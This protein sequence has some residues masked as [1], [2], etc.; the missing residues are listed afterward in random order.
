MATLASKPLMAAGSG[1]Y[2]QIAVICETFIKGEQSHALSLINII[3]G[4]GVGGDDPQQM[5]PTTIGPPLK[6]VVNLWA[7]GTRGRY[8]LK[9][10]PEAPSGLQDDMIEIGSV[11]FSGDA[12]VDTIVP[13]PSYEFTEEGIYWFDVLLVTP[14]EVDGQLLTRISFKVDYQP[15]VTLRR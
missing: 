10:R 8:T 12:G 7:G 1:P 11:Q 2:V 13:M 5:P 4:I 15:V 14:G 3:E 6:L 9:L